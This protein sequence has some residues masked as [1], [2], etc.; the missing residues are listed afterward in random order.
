MMEPP[1]STKEATLTYPPEP[2]KK[3]IQTKKKHAE[4]CFF[5][6]RNAYLRARF[7]PARPNRAEPINQAAAGT[8]TEVT[9]TLSTQTAMFG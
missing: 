3:Q 7:I 1:R 5:V 9:D 6:T 8:G 4:A 2:E